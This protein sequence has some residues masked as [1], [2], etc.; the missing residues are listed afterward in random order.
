MA[1]SN[2]VTKFLF[3]LVLWTILIGAKSVRVLAEKPVIN[4]KEQIQFLEEKRLSQGLILEER[5]RNTR[6]QGMK[7]SRD[8]GYIEDTED[9]IQAEVKEENDTYSEI[10]KSI[11][12]LQSKRSQSRKNV[13]ENENEKNIDEEDIEETREIQPKAE[14]IPLSQPAVNAISETNEG[15]NT[16]SLI[17]Q[18]ETVK[19]LVDKA[20]PSRD[21][22]DMGDSDREMLE[23]IVMA[24]SGGEPYLGQVAVANVV[25]NRVKSKRY[26]S[27]LEGVIFQK[28]Q[29]SPVKN[30]V[31]R[32][33]APNGSVKKAVAE[34]LAGK[35][36]V[37][38]DTL[39]FVNPVLATDQ[40]IPRTKTPVKVI[41]SHTFYK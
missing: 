1:S 10:V 31:I 38:E 32:G 4:T 34:A 23:R 5:Q 24:E 22:I 8:F 11:R 17:G 14:R 40:T 41:G 12:K 2:K 37:A 30:G 36:V 9:E 25:L 18:L 6:V 15:I 35:M 29:F 33:R 21:P 3:V 13:N 26:P 7:S 16:N 27:T 39:Y 28:S 20:V 19:D